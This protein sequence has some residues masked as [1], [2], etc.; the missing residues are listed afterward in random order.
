MFPSCSS[1]TRPPVG[2]SSGG[3]NPLGTGPFD[4]NGNYVEAWADA[5]HK[6]PTRPAT[7][8]TMAVPDNS[9]AAEPTPPPLASTTT[10]DKSDAL[11]P[12]PN[13]AKPNTPPE[14]ASSSKDKTNKSDSSASTSKTSGSATAKTSTSKPKPKSSSPTR[15]TVKKGDTLY[16][17]SKRFKT[18]VA[19]IQKANG[20]SGSNIRVGQKL[21]IPRY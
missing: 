21:V 12:R 18:P 6:W 8:P 15:Y 2:S 4:R 20:I 17:L 5:P 7:M 11:A 13:P 10:E 16:E 3:Y 19:A 14:V 9:L 1:S